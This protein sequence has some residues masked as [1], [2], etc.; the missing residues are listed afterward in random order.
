MVSLASSTSLQ[1]IDSRL[2]GLNLALCARSLTSF[3]RY[4]VGFHSLSTSQTVVRKGFGRR[5]YNLTSFRLNNL[6]LLCHFELCCVFVVSCHCQL[7]K[8][9]CIFSCRFGL[10]EVAVKRR[11]YR[12]G[13]IREKTR[14]G[15]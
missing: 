9:G 14:W 13:E 5:A 10:L 3:R 6:R 4:D 2:C 15:R 1:S 7:K 12:S 8:Q 11:C